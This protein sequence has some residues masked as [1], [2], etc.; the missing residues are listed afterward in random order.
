MADGWGY[1]W[2]S[3]LDKLSWLAII[4][5]SA[6][7]GVMLYSH[8]QEVK[9]SNDTIAGAAERTAQ[10]FVRKRSPEVEKALAATI[11][12]YKE[13]KYPEIIAQAEKILQ[14]DAV[15]PFAY[16]Y[17]A[18]AYR[19]QGNIEQS[20]VNYSEAIRL[21]PDFVDK[22]SEDFLGRKKKELK[23]YV[24]RALIY[25]RKKEFR[26]QPN[27][28]KVLKHLYYLQRRMAGGCE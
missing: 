21:H 7:V 10:R 1:L 28:K 2:E 9:A 24:D 26:S 15:E 13:N 22:K 12:L 16:I 27:Y 25:S 18:R 3:W 6:M 8:Q 14:M 17:L 4:L 11:K 5:I 19:E 20:I 23:P